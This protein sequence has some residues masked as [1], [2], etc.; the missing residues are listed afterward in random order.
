MKVVAMNQSITGKP[1]LNMVNPF[2]QLRFLGMPGSL[3][4]LE[5]VNGN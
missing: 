3:Q 4:S 1:A 2:E 5:A